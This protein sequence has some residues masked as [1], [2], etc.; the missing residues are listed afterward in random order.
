MYQSAEVMVH[1]ALAEQPRN[2]IVERYRSAGKPLD[3]PWYTMKA[4]SGENGAP[5][6][7]YQE[8]DVPLKSTKGQNKHFLAATVQYITLLKLC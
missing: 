2:L 1:K 3:V 6:W 8:K 7:Y 4:T 5:E